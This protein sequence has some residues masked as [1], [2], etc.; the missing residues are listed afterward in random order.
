MR[1]FFVIV[2]IMLLCGAVSAIFDE[3]TIW[4]TRM[5]DPGGVSFRVEVP[6]IS[7]DSIYIDPEEGVLSLFTTMEEAVTEIAERESAIVSVENEIKRLEAE[8]EWMREE[9]LD[10]SD[11]AVA[12]EMLTPYKAIAVKCALI[13]KDADLSRYLELPLGPVRQVSIGQDAK[14]EI[15]PSFSW[16]LIRQI[17]HK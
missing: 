5:E 8:M 17:T 6:L 10:L 9:I 13:M 4:I 1:K 14:G 12:S 15:V 3:D 16:W 2:S 11:M 7:F